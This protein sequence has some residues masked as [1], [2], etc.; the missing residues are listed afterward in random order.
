MHGYSR[1]QYALCIQH[2]ITIIMTI[3]IN[4]EETVNNYRD[5]SPALSSLRCEWLQLPEQQIAGGSLPA[6]TAASTEHL[7][8]SACLLKHNRT[9]MESQYGRRIQ[10]W[11]GWNTGYL[12]LDDAIEFD[13]I[14]DLNILLG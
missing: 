3:N 7:L 1:T 10:H 5:S 13:I 12:K 14:A 11:A 2:V 9:G 8:S 4:T 6:P